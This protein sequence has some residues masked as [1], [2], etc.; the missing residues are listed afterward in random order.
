MEKWLKL[1][2]KFIYD[3]RCK[4]YIPLL[5]YMDTARTKV[6]DISQYRNHGTIY[7]AV[8]DEIGFY[9][10]GTDDY[11]DCGKDESLNITDAI[12]IELW[13]K[14]SSFVDSTATIMEYHYYRNTLTISNGKYYGW[15][16]TTDLDALYTFPTHTAGWRYYTITYNNTDG[17]LRGYSN[18]EYCG[19]KYF[20]GNNYVGDGNVY[21]SKRTAGDS[22][23]FNG[24]IAL[25]RIWDIALSEETIKSHYEIERHLFGV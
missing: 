15:W 5:T 1:H 3:D 6:E 20:G 4:L 21:I 16:K 22:S 25:V 9:F 23:R 8:P 17:Y 10:D 18:G 24:T 11:I 13:A 19:K 14:I 2:R 7:G 12:T